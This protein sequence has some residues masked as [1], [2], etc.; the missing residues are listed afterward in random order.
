MVLCGVYKGKRQSDA[1]DGIIHNGRNL[2]MICKNCNKLEGERWS[3]LTHATASD[4]AAAPAVCAAAELSSAPCRPLSNTHFGPGCTLPVKATMG[5][6]ES[7]TSGT[8]SHTTLQDILFPWLMHPQR[9]PLVLLHL[10]HSMT[11]FEAISSAG[12]KRSTHL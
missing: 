6:R 12:V 11:A 8:T 7:D 5:E 10:N 2:A 3:V 9:G 4:N 1:G